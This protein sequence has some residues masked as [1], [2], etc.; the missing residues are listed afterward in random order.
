MAAVPTDVVRE[1]L[2]AR[3]LVY[4]VRRRDP[5]RILGQRIHLRRGIRDALIQRE[6][7]R[8]E[9]AFGKAR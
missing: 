6:K 4:R 3:V 2:D 7:L 8:A 1:S 5:H 9:Q